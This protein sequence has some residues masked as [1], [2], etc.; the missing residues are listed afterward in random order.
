MHYDRGTQTGAATL[1]L[2]TIKDV[3]LRLRKEV[4]KDK[5]LNEAALDKAFPILVTFAEPQTTKEAT[6][7][8]RK[9]SLPIE[10]RLVHSNGTELKTLKNISIN[11]LKKEII[12][13]KASAGDN[14]TVRFKVQPDMWIGIVKDVKEAIAE[15]YIEK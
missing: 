7:K 4:A 9:T 14:L 6:V 12:A 13:C 1:Y 3:Y 2:A 10:V 11:E 15:A 8:N 5:G